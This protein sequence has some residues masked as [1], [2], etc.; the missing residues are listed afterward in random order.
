MIRESTIQKLFGYCVV[1][2]IAMLL[3]IACN[4]DPQLQNN[5]VETKRSLSQTNVLQIWW[6]K[7][8]YPE[9]DEALR[10]VV[11]SWE[12]K[13]N[14]KVKL[15]FYTNDEL[16]QKTQRAIRAGD[17][18]DI[19][20]NDGGDRTIGALAWQNKLTDVSSVIEPIKGIFEQTMLSS[21]YLY[22]N[23]EQ[24]SSY[25]AIPIH[26]SI[27]HIFYWRDLLTQIGKSDLPQDWNEFWQFWQQVQQELRI[28]QDR[29]IYSI[30]LPLSVAAVDTY[31]IFEQILEAYDVEVVNS[32][33]N[34]QLDVP[35]VKQGITNCLDWYAGFY[36]R[37]YVPP[38]AINWLNPDNNRS[39]LNRQ[40]VMTPNNSLSIPAALGKDSEEYQS[41]LVTA[42]YP[43]KPNGKPMKYIALVRQ[44]IVLKDAANQELAQEFLSYL[45]QPEI[46]G[47][48]L[49]AAGGRFFPVNERS[50]SDP[51]WTDPADPHISTAAKPFLNRQTRLSYTNLNPAYSQVLE[52]G[53]WGQ[54]LNSIVVDKISPEQ[55][56]NNAIALIQKIFAEWEK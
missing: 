18:P 41:Q 26:V 43:N 45:I 46:I 13:T 29:E 24:K 56:A 48:Y 6:D 15:S 21:A 8:Y 51:F 31:E 10:N 17:P 52:E 35:L 25:Y 55:A 23:V 11:R 19:L 28:K 30:G 33:G 54:A 38:A 32:Q 5:K 50:W 16:S 2:I 42:A 3:V 7:G 4:S 39:L 34:L 14:H 20:M 36:L 12:A 47:D 9:E 44:A 27:P 49:K 22:N 40:V 53:I 37:G 1:V